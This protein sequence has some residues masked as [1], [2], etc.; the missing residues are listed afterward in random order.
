MFFFKQVK[1]LLREL[2]WKRTC[3]ELLNLEVVEIGMFPMRERESQVIRLCF[4][5]CSL[6][7]K[8]QTCVHQRRWGMWDML[9]VLSWHFRLHVGSPAQKLTFLSQGLYRWRP[10]LLLRKVWYR[11]VLLSAVFRALLGWR[12][13]ISSMWGLFTWSRIH[14]H[15]L[16]PCFS[17]L[18]VLIS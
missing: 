13:R 7:Y 3:F 12:E 17:Y 15:L 5:P 11:G 9:P 6:S 8:M 4:F 2:R 10:C 18:R 16:S 14:L 1:W